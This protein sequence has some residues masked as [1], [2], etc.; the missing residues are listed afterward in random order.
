ME[1]LLSR[2][3]DAVSRRPRAVV[4]AWLV[5]LAS[6]A[7]FSLHQN[8]R[9][10]SAGWEVPGSQSIRADAL[11]ERFPPVASPTLGVLITGRSEQDVA[12]RLAVVRTSV[13]RHRDLRPAP[14][15]QLAEGRSVLLPLTF[16]GPTSA[17]SDV[18]GELRHELVE[19]TAASETRILGAP[20][21]WSEYQDTSKR[22]LTH[23]EAI[24][25]PLILLILLAGF[26]TLP[27]AL[28]PLALGFAVVL[29]IGAVIYLLSTMVH[30]SIFVTSVASMIGIGVSVDYSLFVVSRYRS[31]LSAH[32]PVMALRRALATSGTAVVFSGI[33]VAFSL[34][35]LFLVNLNAIHSLAIGAIA[36]VLIAVLASVTLLPALL[37]AAGRRIE[38]LR[39]PLGL[40]TGEQGR[41]RL[42]RAWTRK[43]LGHPLLA[44]ALA[45]SVMLALAS[46]VLGLKTANRY[47][48]QLPRDSEVRTATERLQVLAGPGLL[49]PVHLIVRDRGVAEEIAASV[50]R[51][52]GVARVG[53]VLPSSDGRLFL[54]NATLSSDPDLP[55]AREELRRIEHAARRIAAKHDAELVVGGA[56]RV[57]RDV[58]DAVVGALW[59]MI[60]C[61]LIVSYA[62]LLVLLRSVVLP[63]KA[64]AMNLLSVGAAYGVLVAVFQWGWFDWTGYDSPGYI[65]AIVLALILAATFGLS[66]DYEVFLLTRIREQ[67]DQGRSNEDAV[68]A[69]LVASARAITSAAL[70][71]VAVFGAFAI[72]GATS[73]KELGVGLAVAIFLDATLVRLVLVPAT[74]QLLGDLNWW[75]PAPLA[76]VLSR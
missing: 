72:A 12:A 4:A 69:G 65:D 26:G 13:T 59:K 68:R 27:A 76:R 28:A 54:V 60:L 43:T 29:L 11:L 64:V 7:W 33:T 73:L 46:P 39:V 3:A 9:L 16:R 15:L 37:A 23:A 14:A 57:G 17:A 34:L 32:V 67:Y 66:M 74:M 50:A 22:Q 56:T 18:A 36:S 40:G 47:L 2:L 21:V 55:P 71:M 42:W 19:T 35:A 31:E 63:L 6:G 49:A 44:A 52:R 38:R 8:D 24:G 20:A 45:A 1:A 51:L 48:E 70:I 41:E 30:M 53:R 10:S 75:L 61:V 25:F 58:E 5:V 62:V